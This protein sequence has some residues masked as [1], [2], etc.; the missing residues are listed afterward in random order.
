MHAGRLNIH[1][2]AGYF[3]KLQERS[4]LDVA[5]VREDVGELRCFRFLREL[6]AR[7]ALRRGDGVAV[8]A[9]DGARAA[10]ELL[11]VSV[12][13]SGMIRVIGDVRLLEGRDHVTG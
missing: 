10:E 13:A 9:N 2:P 11:A 8:R 6:K 3:F 1:L 12:V 7:F 4:R 5:G